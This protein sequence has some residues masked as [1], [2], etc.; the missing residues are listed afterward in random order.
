MVNRD[1]FLRKAIDKL[2]DFT[3]SLKVEQRDAVASF[4][5]W[6]RCLSRAIR[7]EFDRTR[8]QCLHSYLLPVRADWSISDGLL[9]GAAFKIPS[10]AYADRLSFNAQPQFLGEPARR[11]VTIPRT[12]CS[13]E[14]YLIDRGQTLEG[15]DIG[16]GYKNLRKNFSKRK[17]NR[18]MGIFNS[19]K[20]TFS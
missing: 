20:P 15:K 11:L 3:V 17:E 8:C 13:R 5:S 19:H 10:H 18:L 1:V 9:R 7:E 6:T 4:V 12:P 16:E 2:C 14:V